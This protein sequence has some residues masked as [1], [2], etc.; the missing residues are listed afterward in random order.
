MARRSDVSPGRADLLAAAAI[1]LAALA[2]RLLYIRDVDRA[3][4]SGFLRLD[5]LYYH[6]W[7]VRIARG[8]WLGRDAFEMS[9]LYPYLLGA[10]YRIFGVSLIVPRVLQALLGSLTCAGTAVLGARVFGR[11]AGIIAGGALALYGP[12]VYYDGQINKTTLAMALSVAFAGAL[13]ISGRRRPGWT[14]AGGL[15]L[16]LAA[17]V[18]ENVN[19]VLPIILIWLAWPARGEP[20]RPRLAAAA[21]FLA[22]Y[23]AAVLPV[24]VRNVAVAGEH[25]LITSGGGENFYTG[26]NEQASGRYGPPSFVRPDPFYEHEDFRREAA[27]R[28]GRAVT[29]GEASGF[30][31][32]EGWRFILGHPR[33]YV[34]LLRDKIGV[35]FN[36]FER[37]DNFSYDNFRL[38]SPTLSLPL[39]SFGIVAPLGILGIV[40]SARRWSELVPLYAGF[41]AYLLSAI[42]FFTQSR[43]RMPGVPFLALFAGQALVVL[44]ALIRDRR[45]TRLAAPLAGVLILAAFVNRDPGNAPTFAAQNQAILGELYLNA[46][47]FDEAAAA[48]RRGIEGLSA[49]TSPENPTFSRILGAAHHGLGL[50]EMRRKNTVEAERAL[51]EAARSSDEDVRADALLDLAALLESRKDIAG[52]AEALGGAVEVRP[53]EFHLRV[54][55]AE[56]LY[57]LGRLR[58]SAEQAQAALAITPPP[59]PV[60]LADAWYGLALIRLAGGEAAGAREALQRTLDLNPNHERAGW[61]REALA[62]LP[63]GSP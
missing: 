63:G 10:T 41:G 24:T 2:L 31:W 56:A 17:L 21:A 23:A 8:D 28:L 39:L 45:W 61:I 37:P 30:W 35:F 3:G 19:V 9:P 14:A 4:L 18:H 40:L 33:A 53:G 54:R 49:A 27:R 20:V 38:F 29:R 12:A 22:G 58:E 26:N 25:V 36:A 7:A 51:R 60:E 43:Y 48:F 52:V 5:P 16:G 44:G 47:R 11:T 59:P 13:T 32:R 62:R 34:A 46:G 15:A 6:E 55:Y 42:I 1:F 50:A 57:K